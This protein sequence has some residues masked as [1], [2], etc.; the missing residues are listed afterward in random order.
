MCTGYYHH[1]AVHDKIRS[2]ILLH[3]GVDHLGVLCNG[4][5]KI[6]T[7]NMNKE[8]IHWL[9]G[10]SG[11]Y[12]HS[13]I[14]TADALMIYGGRNTNETFGGLWKFSTSNEQW[15]KL[16]GYVR[17]QSVIAYKYYVLY[18]Y[19]LHCMVTPLHW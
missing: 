16:T 1:V 4:I 6:N 15:L 14:F 9:E 8:Y 17:C 18:M 12:L 2:N 10:P 11:R 3:G 19:R 5:T 7:D 13:G